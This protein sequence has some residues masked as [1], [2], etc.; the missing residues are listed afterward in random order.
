MAVTPDLLPICATC[1]GLV[2]GRI[3]L[4]LSMGF[5]A[6]VTL[7]LR[8]VDIIPDGF[9]PAQTGVVESL[10]NVDHA[11]WIQRRQT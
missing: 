6:A 3:G 7:V 11:L 8:A 1:V 5:A 2:N 9:V 10:T 4:G